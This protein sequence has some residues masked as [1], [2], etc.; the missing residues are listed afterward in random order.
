ML[1]RTSGDEA[2]AVLLQAVGH[3]LGVAQDLHHQTLSDA[4]SHASRFVGLR[5]QR[6]RRHACSSQQA[7][8][9]GEQEISDSPALADL[10]NAVT[11]SWYSLNSGVVACF[12]A[13]ARPLMVWLWGPPCS[14]GMM[15]LDTRACMCMSIDDQT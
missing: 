1:I 10:R 7:N 5:A 13:H 6:P 11:C 12:S 9:A 3:R 15:S 2:V 8:D 4:Q 14:S